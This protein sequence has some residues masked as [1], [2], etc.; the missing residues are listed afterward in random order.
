MIEKEYIACVA[1]DLDAPRIY[2]LCS[3]YPMRKDDAIAWGVKR[4]REQSPYARRDTDK[5]NVKLV[6]SRGWIDSIFRNPKLPDS[7]TTIL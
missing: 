6:K 7:F 5:D 1:C 4:Y 3:K 2:W